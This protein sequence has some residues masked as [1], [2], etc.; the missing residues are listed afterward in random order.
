[1]ETKRERETRN[2]KW[3]ILRHATW[4]NAGNKRCKLCHANG[5]AFRIRSD[6][7]NTLNKRTELFSKC[8]DRNMFNAGRFNCCPKENASKLK[9]AR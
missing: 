6:Q 9:R 8:C 7:K 5:K 2:I 4:H 1:M 3:S